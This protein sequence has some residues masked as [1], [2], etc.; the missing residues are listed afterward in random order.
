MTKR[1]SCPQCQGRIRRGEI[2]PNS[3][4][5][6]NEARADEA[7]A[8]IDSGLT[9]STALAQ[10]LGV[11]QRTALRHLRRNEAGPPP[12]PPIRDFTDEMKA[13]ALVMLED[14]AGYLETAHTLGLDPKRIAR[15]FP[16]YALTKA[17]AVERA[18]MM[19]HAR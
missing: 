8:L 11:S 17:E 10:A 6:L 7:K 14:R 1:H 5:A 4:Q 15:H 18:L 13:Q 3:R 16:G 19:R 9:D 2:C 12:R